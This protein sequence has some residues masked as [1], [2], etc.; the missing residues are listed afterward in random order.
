MGRIA[1]SLFIF[2]DYLKFRNISGRHHSGA[3]A[4]CRLVRLAMPL[5]I[6]TKDESSWL[7]SFANWKTI[8]WPV[9]CSLRHTDTHQDPAYSMHAW[10]ERGANSARWP[11]TFHSIRFHVCCVVCVCVHRMDGCPFSKHSNHILKLPFAA[12][13]L[14]RC[15]R[16]NCFGQSNFPAWYINGTDGKIMQ[17]EIFADAME[18]ANL[19]EIWCTRL[20]LRKGL[21]RPWTNPKPFSVQAEMV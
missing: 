8:W 13:H 6:E 2:G 20:R 5:Q 4:D 7:S 1:C 14:F 16:E 12:C 10:C 21:K 15:N 3:E 17:L 11:R 9:A 18:A 19:C